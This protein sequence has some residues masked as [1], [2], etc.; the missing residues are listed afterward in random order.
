MP[1]GELRRTRVAVPTS[2]THS[3]SGCSPVAASKQARQASSPVRSTTAS[4]SSSTTAFHSCKP[5]MRDSMPQTSFGLP[6]TRGTKIATCGGWG[7]QRT[8]TRTTTT[9]GYTTFGRRKSRAPSTWLRLEDIYIYIYIYIYMV[10]ES[11][12]P[13]PPCLRPPHRGIYR[14]A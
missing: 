13:P 7:R 11:F 9:P 5:Q 3:H 14:R 12:T 6:C 10:H 8:T 1:P 2:N 4:S